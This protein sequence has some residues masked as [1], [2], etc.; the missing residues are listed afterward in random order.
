MLKCG[1]EEENT[2]QQNVGSGAKP[3]RNPYSKARAKAAA[4]LRPSQRL[5]SKQRPE[6]ER[7]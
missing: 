1:S 7:P 3:L 5:Y 6:G 4:A 2:D